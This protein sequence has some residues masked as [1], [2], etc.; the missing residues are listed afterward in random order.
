MVASEEINFTASH[1]N[2]PIGK[3]SLSTGIE[4]YLDL[5]GHLSFFLHSKRG[6][7]GV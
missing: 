2:I 3:L 7:V 1:W 5:Y 6:R 4:P